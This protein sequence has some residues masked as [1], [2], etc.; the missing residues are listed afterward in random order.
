MTYRKS[1]RGEGKVGCVIT[2]II[3]SAAAAT[4][5]KVI[6][7]Y[8]SNNSLADMAVRKAE[9]A[10]G[11]NVEDLTK[12]LRDEARKRDKIIGPRS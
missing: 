10:A 1:E 6:P 7:L 8:Y 4:G 9:T 11:R 2:L 5:L 3:L 12:E